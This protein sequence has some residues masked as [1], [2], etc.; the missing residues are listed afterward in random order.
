M[1]KVLS[2][3]LRERVV[4][5]W[6]RGEGG[7]ETVAAM[8]GIGSATLKRLVRR[9]RETGSLEP[10]PPPKGFP[11]VLSGP[12]LR[13]LALLVARHPDATTAELTE[14]LNQR[15]SVTV[16]RSAVVRA[17]KRLGVTRKKRHSGRPKRTATR[18]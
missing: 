17:L 7:Y 5:A 15:I 4:A 16:S 12:R 1:G 10:D 8:F 6:E 3:D 11:P 13:S 14:L 18:S 2:M 9:K